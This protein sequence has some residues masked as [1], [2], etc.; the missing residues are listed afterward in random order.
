[1]RAYAADTA[2]LVIDD[3]EKLVPAM[4]EDAEGRK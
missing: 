2:L 1:M 3:Q 4:A